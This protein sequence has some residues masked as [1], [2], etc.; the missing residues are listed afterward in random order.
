MKKGVKITIIALCS[1]V[2]LLIA[3]I[4]I[5]LLSVFSPAR[6]T[7]IVN[8]E[9]PKWIAGQLTVE[10]VELTLFKTFPRLGLDIQ[11]VTL[12]NPMFG[13]PSDTLLSVEHCVAA[14][15]LR[16]LIRDN[17]IE[18]KTFQLQNGRI[19]LYTNKIGQSNYNVLL[20]NDNTSSEYKFSADLQKVSTE[21]VYVHYIDLQN[22]MFPKP[23]T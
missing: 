7:K 14:I 2:G 23:T 11:H 18:V 10:R 21:N 5:V 4:G 3:A 9:A 16:K 8:Q 22:K 19:H 6:L 20:S 17:H 13:A 12:I 1:T 15:N